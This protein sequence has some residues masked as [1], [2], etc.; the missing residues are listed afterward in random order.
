MQH[1]LHQWT[2]DVYDPADTKVKDLHDTREKQGIQEK[3]QWCFRIDGVV[4]DRNLVPDQGVIAMNICKQRS[5]DK[6]EYCGSP[7]DTPQL[8][9]GD[10]FS[11]LKGML[12]GWKAG[13]RRGKINVIGVHDVKLQR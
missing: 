10:C 2:A 3:F 7:C 8:P 13:T 6:R 5:V 11:L 12:Q 9:Q 4:E 1:V